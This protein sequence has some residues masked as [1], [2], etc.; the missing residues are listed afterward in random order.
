MTNM[1]KQE[2]TAN[3]IRQAKLLIWDETPM[4]KRHTI[5]T[6][7]RS[8]RDIM[9]NNLPFGGNIMVFGGDFQQVLPVVP[10]STRAETVDASLVR[11][12]LWPLMEKIHLTTNMRARGDPKFSDFL[13][14]FMAANTGRKNNPAL[15]SSSQEPSTANIIYDFLW[16]N[17]PVFSGSKVEK[18]PQTF[19]DDIWKI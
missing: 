5:K 8:F 13:L 2:G 19:I 4:T 11:S 17:P 6:V 3:L 14:Q 9:D 15:N 16:K 12:Y 1:L 10:K 18:D 7:D